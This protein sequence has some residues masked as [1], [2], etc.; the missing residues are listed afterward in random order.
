MS[1][2]IKSGII[3]KGLS[4]L[5]EV[6]LDGG[7]SVMCPARG[8][9]RHEGETVAA[10]DRCVL[11]MSPDGSGSITEILPRRNLLMRPPIANLDTLFIVIAAAKP[12]PSPF[13]VDKL[14]CIAVHND[15]TPKIV[16]N[17]KELD[18]E[19][20][21]SLAEIYRSVGFETF[22]T[23]CESGEGMKELSECVASLGE[24]SICAFAGASG[25]GK[26]TLLGVLFPDMEF[27]TGEISRKNQRG[28]HTTRHVELYDTGRAY[29]ADTPG[30]TL[31]DFTR[32]DFFDLDDLPFTFPEF[33]EHLENPGCRY[34]RCTHKTEEGCAVVDALNRGLIPFQ[35]HESYCALWEELKEKRDREYD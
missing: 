31:L 33:A 5:Y 6:R 26:S 3:I 15:I 18:P 34:T 29:V 4:G 28:R 22:L 11:T 2:N 16:I 1:D 30:F 20:A 7:G 23:S 21:E 10:G 25:V 35:R 14:T 8:L 24:G 19:R 17:K 32:Y 27:A 13:T 9:F 12:A